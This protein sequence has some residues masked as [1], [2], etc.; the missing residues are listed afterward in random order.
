ME[1]LFSR[2]YP[3]AFATRS[4][5]ELETLSPRPAP[6]AVKLAPGLGKEAA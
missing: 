5:I 3:N 1:M 4:A 2:V 6:P